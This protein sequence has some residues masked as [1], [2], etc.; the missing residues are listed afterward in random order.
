MKRTIITY[1]CDNC[2][3]E[4]TPEVMAKKNPIPANWVALDIIGNH[5]SDTDMLIC[6]DCDAAVK[7]ALK[8]R[9]KQVKD[10]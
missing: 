2:G 9:Q 4:S 8:K 1:E 3:A 5:G 7:K 10:V 6:D